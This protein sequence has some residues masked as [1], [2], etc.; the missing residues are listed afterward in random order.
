LFIEVKNFQFIT[1]PSE[2]P[3]RDYIVSLSED[4]HNDGIVQVL[5]LADVFSTGPYGV[6]IQ[7]GLCI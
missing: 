3:P 6:T 5:V 4:F 7:N 1:D 2:E